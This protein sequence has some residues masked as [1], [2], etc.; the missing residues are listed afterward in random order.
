MSYARTGTQPIDLAHE[1]PVD[2][3]HIVIG[4]TAQMKRCL[5]GTYLLFRQL[6]CGAVPGYA[7]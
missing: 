5:I 2:P 1:H 7:V 3:G 6:D 4:N